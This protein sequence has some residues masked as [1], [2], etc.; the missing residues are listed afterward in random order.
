MG[1]THDRSLPPHKP[2]LLPAL[3]VAALALS[4]SAKGT[5]DKETD[6]LSVCQEVLTDLL[7]GEERIPR[8]LL[9]K[10]HC[11]AVIPDAKKLALG[12]GARFGK[13]AVL[14]RRPGG[15]DWGPPLMITL[16]GGSVG[17]QI[18]GQDADYVF[19]VMNRRGIDHLLRSKFSLGADA[20]VAAGPV[21]RTA[22]AA[23]DVTMH[24]EILSYSRVRGIFAGLSLE[25]AVL[26]QDKD[27]NRNLYGHA[28][29]A[30]G[31]LAD[32]SSPIPDAARG[33]VD[34]L[35][36]ASPRLAARREP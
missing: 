29:D 15:E 33:L 5:Q 6:R 9:D 31:L 24:A 8:D 21:G 35:D 12:I 10:A 20:A 26:K 30:R 1:S 2:G 22:A 17:W 19:L 11:V 23:T 14:C 34:V 27:G 36:Q 13:G 3:A 16:G 25:G 7:A 18:G 4:L 28:V 32:G